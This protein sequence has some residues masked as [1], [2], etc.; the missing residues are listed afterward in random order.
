MDCAADGKICV[1]GSCKKQI[2]GPNRNYCQDGSVYSCDANGTS[3]ILAQTCN[4]QTEHCTTYSSSSYAYCEKNACHAGDTVCADNMIKVC[5]AD[6]SLP[7]NG[8][9]CGTGQYCENAQCKDLGCVPGAYYCKG[10]DV[11]Y[12][13]FNGSYL[14][15]QCTPT[16]PAK[17]WAPVARRAPHSLARH[18]AAPA[19][20]TRSA[21]ARRTDAA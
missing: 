15:E 8:T 18:P 21:P 16:K 14:S 3:T 11:Y 10:A 7:V 9:S 6:G 5:N 4:S 1:G 13:D 17:R 19:S 20:A 12:C 2:C